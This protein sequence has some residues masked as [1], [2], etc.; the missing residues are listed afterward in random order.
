MRLLKIFLAEGAA[1]F[2]K[3]FVV[4]LYAVWAVKLGFIDTEMNQL[5]AVTMVLLSIYG[6]WVVV[7]KA[8]EY[9]IR[10]IERN[11]QADAVPK[12]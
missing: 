8:S 11:E 10:T 3:V 12:G 9:L 1:T 6:L 7:R 5:F 2:L 4:G